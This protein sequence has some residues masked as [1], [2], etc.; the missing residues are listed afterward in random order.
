MNIVDFPFSFV[1]TLFISFSAF[2][3]M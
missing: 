1:R 2:I 3:Y